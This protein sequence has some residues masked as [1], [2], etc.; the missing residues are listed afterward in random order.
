M[1]Y[2][3]MMGRS[4]VVGIGDMV[5]SFGDIADFLGGTPSSE[6]SKNIYGLDTSKP[7]SDAFHD[8]ADYLQSYGDTVPGLTDMQDISWDDLAE[9]EFW[10]TGVAR[11][12][13]FALSLLV[14]ATGAAKIA[15]MATKGSKFASASKLIAKGAKS[16]GATKYANPLAARGLIRTGISMTSAGAASN[17]IEGAALAGQTLNQAIEEGVPLEQAKLAASQVYTDNLASMAVDIV[18]YGL[19]MGQMKVGKGMMS[20]GKG[21]IGKTPLSKIKTP[22][23][24]GVVKK[25]FKSI[26][27]GAA[28]G[29]TDGVAEQFQE[30]YQE[31]SVQR[32]VAEAK[33]EG[34]SF[35]SYMDFFM[36]DEQRPTRVLSFATSLLM[37]GASNVV[38]TAAENRHYLDTATS[39]RDESHEFLKVFN[40]NLD[41]GNYTFKRKVKE[42][43]KNGKVV[44]REVEETLNAEEATRYSR[45]T[46]ART[47]IMNAVTQNDEAVLEEFFN[48]QLESGNISESQHSIYMETLKEVKESIEGMPSGDLDNRAKTEL[49]ANAWLNKASTTSLNSQKET[50]EANIASVNQKVEEGVL[51]RETADKEIAGMRAAAEMALSEQES[52]IKSSKAR[53][54]EI[55]SESKKRQENEA[56]KKNEGSQIESLVDK[57]LAGE[58]LTQEEQDLIDKDDR[59][60]NYYQ[61]LKKVKNIEKA[62]STAKKKVGSKKFKGY[63]INKEN[64]DGSIEFIKRDE[65]NKVNNFI[66]V[67]KEGNV[68]QTSTKDT[69]SE[70]EEKLKNK[71]EKEKQEKESKEEVESKE[72]TKESREGRS[73]KSK[74][75]KS[76]SDD[77]KSKVKA[78]AAIIQEVGKKVIKNFFSKENAVAILDAADRAIHNR[79]MRRAYILGG[80]SEITLANLYAKKSAD[81]LISVQFVNEIFS[82]GDESAGYAAGLSVMINPDAPMGDETLFHEN[83]HIF[84]M[85]Y[86]HLP[87]VQEMMKQVVGQPVYEATKLAYQENLIYVD[88]KGNQL[89]QEEALEKLKITRD[90][91]KSD[92]FNQDVYTNAYDYANIHLNQEVDEKTI[93][94][95][96]NYAKDL[97]EFHRYSELPAESQVNI[98]DEALAKLGG[99]YG[100]THQ[101]MY[102]EQE[103][104]K[105]FNDT[106]KSWKSKI[107]S[108]TTKEEAETAF[109]IASKGLYKKGE[110]Y[111]LEEAFAGIKDLISGNNALYAEF[112][113]TSPSTISIKK[114]KR[115][116]AIESINKE[117]NSID[118]IAYEMSREFFQEEAAKLNKEYSEMTDEE[119]RE[120]IKAKVVRSSS[121]NVTFS[122]LAEVLLSQYTP[123]SKN[124]DDMMR[125]L[126]DKEESIKDIIHKQHMSGL[127]KEMESQ[128][129]K[130][131]EGSVSE[132]EDMDEDMDE[133]ELLEAQ[134]SKLESDDVFSSLIE[135][136][137]GLSPKFQSILSH[138]IEISSYNDKAGYDISKDAVVT[139]IKQYAESFD[140][141][142]EFAEHA[143]GLAANASSKYQIDFENQTT[144]VIA[145]FFKLLEDQY[146]LGGSGNIYQALY[147]QM[148]SMYTASGVVITSDG[149]KPVLSSQQAT[150]VSRA[151]GDVI[152]LSRDLHRPGVSKPTIHK[153]NNARKALYLEGKYAGTE[154]ESIIEA[155]SARLRYSQD[156]ADY[157]YMSEDRLK[158]IKS[159]GSSKDAFLAAIISRYLLPGSRT[160]TAKDLDD[161]LI[162]NDNETVTLREYFSDESLE[163]MLWESMSMDI[164]LSEGLESEMA[165]KEAGD[166]I[167][168]LV[169]EDHI[170]GFKDLRKNISKEKQ[171]ELWNRFKE[172]AR[173]EANKESFPVG[174]EHLVVDNANT[175]DGAVVSKPHKDKY[176]RNPETGVISQYEYTPLSKEEYDELGFSDGDLFKAS[177]VKSF[178]DNSKKASIN[179]S[180]VENEEGE[181]NVYT[182]FNNIQGMASRAKAVNQMYEAEHSSRYYSSVLSPEG[183]ILNMVSRKFFLEYGKDALM[184][185][186]AKSESQFMSL[187]SYGQEENPLARLIADN[188]LNL[189][190]SLLTGSEERASDVSGLTGDYIHTADLGIINRALNGKANKYMQPVRDYSDKERRYYSSVPLIRPSKSYSQ[191]MA[192]ND[193]ATNEAENKENILRYLESEPKILEMLTKV[194]EYHR[195][196]TLDIIN[197]HNDMAS[198]FNLFNMVSKDVIAKLE[199]EGYPK[200]STEKKGKGGKV[201]NLLGSSAFTQT[202]EGKN[203][204]STLLS[205][206]VDTNSYGDD[207]VASIN[208]MYNKYFL[209]DLSSNLM[210]E[211]GFTAK[212]KRSTGFIAPHDSIYTGQR[213]ETLI[214]NDV[215][216]SSEDQSTEIMVY[217]SS[218]PGGLKSV[219]LTP[220]I[221][222]S[223]SYITEA[224]MRRLESKYS[225]LADVKGSFKLVGYGRN[226]DN[227]TISSFFGMN[228]NQFYFK[229]HT[230]VLNSKVSGP[231]SAV[232]KAL[233]A[234]EN[235]YKEQGSYNDH[236]ILAYADSGV[237]KG[238]LNNVNKID[239]ANLNELVKDST[240][241]NKWVDSYSHDQESGVYGYDGRYFG[242]QNEL[243]KKSTSTTLS[244]QM[245]S[246][247]NS[248]SGHKN[249]EVKAKA[250]RSLELISEL[251]DMQYQEIRGESILGM[252]L[253]SMEGNN[254]VSAADKVM[255]AEQNTSHPDIVNKALSL[256]ENKIKKKVFK[257]RTKGTLSL[258]ES[259]VIHGFSFESNKV[260]ETENALKPFSLKEVDGEIVVEHAEAVISQHMAKMLG[261]TKKSLIEAKEKG[262][263]ILFL[264]TR[265][266][267]SSLGSTVV[268]KVAKISDKPGNTIAVN[269]KIS[270]IL[271]SDLDGDMLHLNVIDKDS[272]SEKVQKTNEILESIIELY[273]T[274]EVL[275][276]LAFAIEF[277]STTKKTNMALYGDVSGSL[278]VNSDFNMIGT[279]NI[280][281]ATKGNVP[282]IGII[283]AQSSAYN[284]L[285]EGS[286]HILFNGEPISITVDGKK[287]KT[288][289]DSID[290]DGVGTYQNITR[291]LNLV[292]DDGQ[293][294]NRAKFQFVKETAGMFTMMLKMGVNPETVSKF[295]RDSNWVE[296]MEMDS[297]TLNDLIVSRLSTSELTDGMSPSDLITMFGFN[298]LDLNSILEDES[299]TPIAVYLAKQVTSDLFEASHFIGLDKSFSANPALGVVQ[300]KKAL[301][302][303]HRQSN[304]AYNGVGDLLAKKNP[305]YMTNMKVNEDLVSH[306]IE[307]SPLLS[308]GYG[309]GIFGNVDASSVKESSNGILN[310]ISIKDNLHGMFSSYGMSTIAPSNVEISNKMMSALNLSR[311]MLHSGYNVGEQLSSLF[312]LFG[313]AELKNEFAKLSTADKVIALYN[314]AARDIMISQDDGDFAGNLW[315]DPEGGIVSF[316]PHVAVTYKNARNFKSKEI[317]PKDY[318]RININ[319]SVL[320]N[321]QQVE[322]V[323]MLRKDFDKLPGKVRNLLVL[324]DLLTTGWGSKGSGLSNVKYMGKST[325]KKINDFFSKVQGFTGSDFAT[326]MSMIAETGIINS[327]DINEFN[328]RRVAAIA[329]LSMHG[330]NAKHSIASG[331]SKYNHEFGNMFRLSV[332]KLGSNHN[333]YATRISIDN[334]VNKEG[335]KI[336]KEAN[337]NKYVTSL[338]IVFYSSFPEANMAAYLNVVS[339]AKDV[340]PNDRGETGIKRKGRKMLKIPNGGS[341]HYANI[342]EVMSPGQYASKVLPHGVSI[343]DLNDV[344]REEFEDRYE[345]YTQSVEKLKDFMS[346]EGIK[347]IMEDT[348]YRDSSMSQQDIDAKFKEALNLFNQVKHHIDS[349]RVP[350]IAGELKSIDEHAAHPIR[351]YMEYTFGNH[352]AEKQIADWEKKHNRSFVM[353]I[354]DEKRKK[355]ISTFKLWMSPGD[356]GMNKPAIAYVNKNMKINHMR[357]T[358]NIALVTKDMNSKLS[359]LVAEKFGE[360]LLSKGARKW[361]KYSPFGTMNIADKLFENLYVSRSGT[362]KIIEDG[363]VRYSDESSLELNPD[364]FYSNKEGKTLR[365]KKKGKAYQSLTKA[366]REYLEMYVK[367]TKFYKDLIIAKGLYQ[368]DKGAS[369]VPNHTSGIWESYQK[370]GLFGMYYSM[371]NGDVDLYDIIIEAENPITG[372]K[373]K[374]SYFSWKT[375]YMHEAGSSLTDV[376]VM[377]TPEGKK[378]TKSSPGESLQQM[379]SSERTVEFYKIRRLADAAVKRGHDDDSNTIDLNSP[380]NDIMS[381]ES[382]EIRNRNLERRSSRAAYLASNNI[383]QSL[384]KYVTLMMFQHGNTFI[385][386]NNNTRHLSWAGDDK[387]LKD[388]IVLEGEAKTGLEF[389]G[390]VDAIPVIDAAISNVSNTPNAAKYLEKVVR[391]GIIKKE[392]NLTLSGKAFEKNIANFFTQWTMYVALGFNAP[393][394]VGNVL[395]GK[396]NTYRQNGGK[397]LIIG[398]SRYWGIGQDKLYNHTSLKKGRKMIEEFGILTYKAEELAEG[399]G[400]GSFSSL[401]FLPMVFAENWIQKAQFLGSLRKESWDAYMIDDNGDLVFKG[402]LT[403]ENGDKLYPEVEEAHRITKDEVIKLE[404][405]VIEVQGRGYS[406]TDVRFIQ[407]YSLGNMVMQFK[408]W[409]PT[410]IADRFKPEDINDLGNMKIGSIVAGHD[411]ITKMYKEGKVWNAKELRKELK[412]L[413]EHR[414]QSIM[415]LWRGTTGI[416]VAGLLFY[417]SKLHDE[418]EGDG[419]ES[420]TTKLFDKLLGDMLL[421]GNVPKLI[422]MTNIPALE[423]AKNLA[424]GMYHT[425][426][427]T[428]YKRKSKYGDKGD[429]KSTAHFAR[430]LPKPLRKPLELKG[431]KSRS[432]R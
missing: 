409:F 42:T 116:A 107:K 134:D 18:Q 77:I 365:L 209:Q 32:R 431:S 14:P 347:E 17:L 16:I 216:I 294:N 95:F 377:T 192:E 19:F 381:V 195:A 199:K 59:S 121:I 68:T 403:N 394:A 402:D 417:M 63:T 57:E 74:K 193:I 214:F 356:F 324:N 243:D 113:N 106:L 189:N 34:E 173:Q 279:R 80:G 28:H 270:H 115:K 208:Y 175:F 231:L 5:D 163:A 388:S 287:Y 47:M 114:L 368:F 228:S 93:K 54:N 176:V 427:G 355:D 167:F 329:Y 422:Y 218:V 419:R 26:G 152:M 161:L 414:Q 254:N 284:Y 332:N 416:M 395:I 67:D 166:L 197:R 371:F 375:I 393:A 144:G 337:H 25:A 73:K 315:L 314:H 301:Q 322:Q 37:S 227:S 265:I 353:E 339:Q 81:G 325:S 156:L 8:F 170:K 385:D 4:F 273:S 386:I 224:E 98:Q 177:L 135:G 30:V 123:N 210:E 401:I 290:V 126:R 397:N 307:E 127:T 201:L 258:Q 15:S 51:E 331:K 196:K 12:L 137:K 362:K 83:F 70:V 60:K 96:Y 86:G 75:D 99:L 391:D 33:G 205:F 246:A 191:W 143:S 321:I 108:S 336:N 340:I 11:M 151:V 257:S 364:F 392:K 124:F 255:H 241:F 269:S 103:K 313:N 363:E 237:K 110:G 186:K 282:M 318:Y 220:A 245:I 421:V 430:L 38:S 200:I 412:S 261:V 233:K 312:D 223:A 117:L 48:S 411:F 360:G 280:Y 382:A 78:S 9:P 303:L 383:H 79:K 334:Q 154:V 358:R 45:D 376:E 91:N 179:I 22:K 182:H 338:P 298:D 180:V 333:N 84:R 236:A 398:E 55:Y 240:E 408:R 174:L 162:Y 101:D 184:E 300:H 330:P 132:D 204:D 118:G 343:D 2:G 153:L 389:S 66:T 111:S 359:A 373:E 10:A 69:L 357:Y 46:A 296:Y 238:G 380:V 404:R 311:V 172:H 335:I 278:E 6:V 89:T 432:I 147:S 366:E 299:L 262:E 348:S 122:K 168:K 71:H 349:G 426:K 136:S 293:N 248:L 232:Y 102:L 369:Y 165:V 148:N 155:F 302:S 35:P 40:D 109:E 146:N 194:R 384:R 229:G 198:P 112:A 400:T 183:N 185:L 125:V 323:D 13:P 226:I 50:L 230:I 64:K 406:E 341:S 234:R 309:E 396:Y 31:W 53:I 56:W 119:I 39:K 292:L 252:G 305:L 253:A 181:V 159:K 131:M 297:Y 142:F 317:A 128:L 203:V 251:V 320:S 423:T 29:I 239:L 133:N 235:F 405:D 178:R 346:D 139:L 256:A 23:I 275:N 43:D 171:S 374:L 130:A 413:P 72:G 390:F 82:K 361:M 92:L 105:T 420:E 316:R 379:T 319:K 418:D 276:M 129:N 266:P 286:P 399:A 367:Y 410:F 281:S 304:S 351:R 27:M 88:S 138:F 288:L 149:I 61:G 44:E 277:E 250:L 342:G 90:G 104:I 370:R 21:A 345:A 306:S 97:L 1:G 202:F 283:A 24:N 100:S 310:A 326:D 145:P 141:G 52:I 58:K 94:E 354:T 187:F 244:K 190:Y 327:S 247:F 328:N 268:L 150:R 285:A 308:N 188:K 87:E 213:V 407:L 372:Q 207:V 274:P 429:K 271:G 120:S 169:F 350:G 85:L 264:A 49:V 249:P 217:D 157:L 164:S 352:I 215:D 160:V 425:M 158:Y 222:D 272:K 387:A 212:T 260:V 225:S 344:Q 428:E 263:D 140:N 3:E 291:Y 65:K 20:L 415:R 41:E 295:M 219:E 206:H 289:D 259:D 267:S 211:G 424:Q 76:L 378:Y 7:I 62:V 221:M 242:V 36:S